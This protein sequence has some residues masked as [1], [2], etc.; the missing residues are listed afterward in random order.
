MEDAKFNKLLNTV[1]IARYGNGFSL[2]RFLRNDLTPDQKAKIM[3]VGKKRP[4]TD[5]SLRYG[6]FEYDYF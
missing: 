1:Q 3:E 2:E 4:E 5:D 6:Y